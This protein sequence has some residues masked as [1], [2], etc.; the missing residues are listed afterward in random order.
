MEMHS[1]FPRLA[2]G[3]KEESREWR[4][5]AAVDIVSDEEGTD[6]MTLSYEQRSVDTDRLEAPPGHVITGVRMRNI[7]G[8]VNLEARV[9]PVKFAEGRLIADRS[10]W[11][12]NDNTPATEVPRRQVDILVPDLPTRSPAASAI[13]T[14]HNQYVMFDSTSAAK[15]VSMHFR[16]RKR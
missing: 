13:D 1:L 6:F 2:G 3:V 16:N 9:T 10:T 7:G 14:Q 8:H 5:P 4:S 12:G 15:D 11:V